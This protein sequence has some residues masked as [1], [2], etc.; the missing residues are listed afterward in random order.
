MRVLLQQTLLHFSEQTLTPQLAT[1]PP[2]HTKQT[3]YNKKT[4]AAAKEAAKLGAKVACLDFV[5]PS[6]AGT[7]W[8]LG[9]TCVNVGCIPKKLM[10]Q[11]GILGESF[12][13][14]KEYGWK[15]NSD[16]HDWGKMVG[17][18]QDHIGSLNFGYRTAL[19][20][21]NVTY[22][23]AY[24]TFVDAHTITATKKNGKVD[25]IT[26]DKFV[27][28]VGGRP[29]YLDAPGAKVGRG[30]DDDCQ[31]TIR[32]PTCRKNTCTPVLFPLSSFSETANSIMNVVCC[33]T[34]S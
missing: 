21:N 5:K 33:G 32:V 24:G 8:G 22:M 2:P 28:A 20:D 3:E 31:N 18:I 1:P 15:V 4:Q 12:S 29:S 26:A 34:V 16:G 19:R 6:P 27:I 14:A 9:G 17:A 23:N 30:G 10:H 7:T 25:T 13:D 11:A